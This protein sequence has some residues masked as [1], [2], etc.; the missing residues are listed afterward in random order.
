MS[1]SKAEFVAIARNFDGDGYGLYGETRGRDFDIG[2][3]EWSAEAQPYVDQGSHDEQ[4]HIWARALVGYNAWAASIGRPVMSAGDYGRAGASTVASDVLRA[5]QSWP[6]QQHVKGVDFSTWGLEDLEWTLAQIRT[7]VGLA[8][9]VL[10][11]D[12]TSQVALGVENLQPVEVAIAEELSK[13][14]VRS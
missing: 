1:G 4:I 7:R 12:P 9:V 14:G 6:V 3:V 8:G 10:S 2:I 11:N 13:R 5:V